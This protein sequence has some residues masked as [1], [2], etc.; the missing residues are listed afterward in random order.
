MTFPIPDRPKG[1]H[2]RTYERLCRASRDMERL[3]CRNFSAINYFA[4][5]KD[6]VLEVVE[7][8]ASAFGVVS[9]ERCNTQDRVQK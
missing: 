9:P 5:Q 3:L 6:H 2:R 1:M 7:T 8:C 4:A